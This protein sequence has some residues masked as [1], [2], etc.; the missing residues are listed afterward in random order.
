M[1]NREALL[2]R[3]DDTLKELLAVITALDDPGMQITP[4]WSAG[5][6]LR[7][8]TFW[9]ES[10]ARNLSDLAHR[11]K[12]NPLKGKYVDLNRRSIEELEGHSLEM[13]CGRLESA[14][15]TI[16]NHILDPNLESIPY[17]K[18]SRDYTPE[19]HLEVVQVH[20]QEHLQ[21]IKRQALKGTKNR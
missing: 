7:H 17:R 13:I 16:R 6:I 14:H 19:E 9:H 15:R 11:R 18:G 4:E 1:E 2:S 12:P 3:L 8:L 20:I 10:F 5:D 21:S